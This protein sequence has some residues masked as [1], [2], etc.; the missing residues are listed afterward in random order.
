VLAVAGSRLVSAVELFQVFL[1]KT[2]CGL[3]LAS[4]VVQPPSVGIALCA[5]SM[6]RV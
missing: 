5:I 4:S 2:V 3:L 6:L 1:L